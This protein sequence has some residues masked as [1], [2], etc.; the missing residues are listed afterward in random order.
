MNPET[1]G[2]LADLVAV[3]HLLY[4][5]TIVIGLLLILCGKLAGWSWVRNAWLRLVH[6]LMIAVV[7]AEAWMGITCPLTIWERRLRVAAG[8]PF[9]GESWLGRSIHVLLFF[10]APWWVFT[11][12]YTAC[13]LLIAAS[14]ILVPPRFPTRKQSARVD[15]LEDA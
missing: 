10:D 2:I 5:A 8:Q 1:Y 3:V 12:A 14:L 4:A 7:V 6:L 13:G 11:T 9:D 15:D